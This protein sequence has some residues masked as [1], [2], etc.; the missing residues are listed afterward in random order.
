EAV[1]RVGPALEHAGV[2]LVASIPERA[3][4][5]LDPD[6]VARILQNLLD[7]A[8]KYGRGAPDRTVELTVADAPGG[9][10]L[11]EVADRGPGVPRALARRLFTPFARGAGPDA[12]AGLGLGLALSRALAG[13]MGGELTYRGRDGG[14]ALFALRLPPA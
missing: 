4:A 14:G 11:I 3:P 6:A 1:A 13:A 8:E 5:R 10:A 7:N 12:P 9:G 2:T